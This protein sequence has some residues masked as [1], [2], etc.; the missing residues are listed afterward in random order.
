MW[1][2]LTALSA[3][4]S[5]LDPGFTTFGLNVNYHAYKN[6]TMYANLR[7]ALDRHYEREIFGF[8]AP[9][10]NVVAGL[11]WNLVRCSENNQ[12]YK[13]IREAQT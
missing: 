11:K 2:R 9:R 7:N 13:K 6:V 4:C 5:T 8:P 1:T 3:G 12:T 10:L